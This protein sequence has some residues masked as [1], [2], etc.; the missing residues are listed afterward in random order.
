MNARN[1]TLI[2]VDIIFA[3]LALISG[4]FFLTSIVRYVVSS[5]NLG[6]AAPWTWTWVGAMIV[7]LIIT[8]IA[9]RRIDN[10]PLRMLVIIGLFVPQIVNLLMDQTIPFPEVW[11]LNP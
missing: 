3:I 11:F 4:T 1:R 5:I 10:S 9:Y 2:F 6:S 8:V 7:L